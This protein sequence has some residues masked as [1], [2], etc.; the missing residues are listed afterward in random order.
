MCHTNVVG[1]S[2]NVKLLLIIVWKMS[3]S[4]RRSKIL[5][6]VCVMRSSTYVILAAGKVLINVGLGSYKGLG[7]V[8]LP[9][10][11]VLKTVNNHSYKCRLNAKSS[12]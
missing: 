1:M 11:P 4:Q 6:Y 10:C 12:G 5:I 2:G 8:I 9:Q 3:T 7:Y